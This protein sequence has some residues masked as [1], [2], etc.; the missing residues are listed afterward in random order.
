MNSTVMKQLKHKSSFQ[1]MWTNKIFYK[2][3]HSFH[4]EQSTGC[5][6]IVKLLNF[7]HDALLRKTGL[8]LNKTLI[9]LHCAKSLQNKKICHISICG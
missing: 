5:I 3:N 7:Y 1:S 8:S 9:S 4:G 2:M 6:P